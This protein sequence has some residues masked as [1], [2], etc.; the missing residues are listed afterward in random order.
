MPKDFKL[1]RIRDYG[2]YVNKRD[3]TDLD[4]VFAVE[5]S[6]NVISRDE[7]YVGTRAG[8]T[9]YGA[10][11]ASTLEPITAEYSWKTARGDEIML[12]GR[13]DASNNGTLEFIIN[14]IFD[15]GQG[16]WTELI[17]GL[18]TGTFRFTTYWDT[19]EGQDA[20]LFVCGDANIYYWSGGVTTFAS[21]TSN[22]ITKQGTTSWA[23]EG[24]LA[25][26]TRQVTIEGTT[27][28]YTGGESTTTLTGVTPD[29][30][31][32]GHTVGATVLQ[33][34]RT[35]SNKPASGLEN[36]LIATV[37][38]QVYVADEKRRD[39]YVS[40]VD[41]YTT[42]TFS[43]PRLVG[44]GALM[45][46]NESPTAMIE[47]EDTI[48]ISTL[49]QWYFVAFTLSDDLQNEDLTIQLLKSSPLGGAVNQES[50]FKIKNDI[51]FVS[52][53]PTINSLGRIENV[54]TPQSKD[55]SDPIKL[56]LNS[57]TL[58]NCSGKFFRNNAYFAFP[59]EGKMLIY[60]IEKGFWEAPQILPVRVMS[61]FEGDLYGHSNSVHETYKLFDGTNDNGNAMEA[62]L[63]FNYLDY[64]TQS[65]MKSFTELFTHGYISTNTDLNI[66]VLYDFKGFNGKQEFEINGGA[67]DATIFAPQQ[68]GNLGKA[69]LGHEPLGT[70]GD[71]VDVLQKF[72]VVKVTPKLN[73][74]EMQVE[75]SSNDID[76]QWFLLDQGTN[77]TISVDDNYAIKQ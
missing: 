57:Y 9:V 11:D 12:R 39:V 60:N 19:T 42:Y 56:E 38:N 55:L 59:S 41:D 72:R 10:E 26:G 71:D 8:Y 23:E 5:G 2:G 66:K 32:A 31:S 28:T 13:N 7:G 36:T 34:V 6:Q 65:A 22:T 3:V 74:Y 50:V 63:V 14:A 4:G 30:T 35:T 49:N 15:S 44:E 62:R 52:N 53:E 20:L 68:D 29:P 51:M 37:R 61:V 45:T 54:D 25:N 21:A 16:L 40:A 18:G 75:Y 46:L 73:F 17:N 70:T 67:G 1:S 69:P 48:Y 47:Q 33:T 58:T 27:Y 76:Q 77:A 64:G 43:S 24:F